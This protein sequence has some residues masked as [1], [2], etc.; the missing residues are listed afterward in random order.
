MTKWHDLFNTRQYIT[1]TATTG[2]IL[3]NHIAGEMFYDSLACKMKIFTGKVWIAVGEITEEQQ[4]DMLCE[5]HPILK[6]LRDARDQNPE[7]LEA[8]EKFEELKALVRE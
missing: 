6:E 7:S 4:E 2:P 3:S 8:R 5:K 1:P